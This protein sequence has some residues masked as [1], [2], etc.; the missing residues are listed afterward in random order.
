MSSSLSSSS[1]TLSSFSATPPSQNTTNFQ[2]PVLRMLESCKSTKQLKQIHSIIIKTATN[3]QT[4]HLIYTKILSICS[5]TSDIDPTYINS[6]FT[7]IPNPNTTIYTNA[8]RCFSSCKNPNDISIAFLLY[9]NF[10]SNGFLPNNYTFPFIL[11]SCAKTHRLIEGKQCH[12]HVIKNGFQSD[13]YVVNNLLRMYAVCGEITSVRQLFDESPKR[14]LVSWTT[15]I[16]AYV[17]IG[18]WEEGIHMFFNLCESNLLADEKT[19]VVV[20]SACANIGDL[21]LGRKLHDYIEHHRLTIDIFV[22]NS[23]ID[24]Y[25]K[26]GDSVSAHKVF[27]KMRVRNVVSWNSMILGLSQHGEY[28]QALVVFRKMLNRSFKPD[29]V[30][31]VGVLNCCSNLGMLELGKWVHTYLDKNKIKSDGYI[32][33]A[34]IDMYAKCGNISSSLN[35]FNNMKTKDVYT[36]T[37][38]I[39]GLAMNGQG[40]KALTLF[41]EM[42][43]ELIEPDHVTYVGVL[44]ACSHSGFV[45]LG[46]RYFNEMSNIYNIK[47]RSEHYGCIVDL[48]GRAGLID[49][50]EEFV[51]NMPIEPDGFVLGALLGACRIHNRVQLARVLMEK[52]VEIDHDKDG[53]Y[54]IMSNIY[55]SANK[56]GE[57]GKLRKEMKEKKV[58]KIPGCSCIE[59]DGVVYEFRK[60]DKS[61][62]ENEKIYM[63]LDQL[64]SHLRD[65]NVL[66]I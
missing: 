62:R 4:H 49:E 35:V 25:L 66:L 38:I 61:H 51:R 15:L 14:D 8:I 16:Q 58:K 2:I 1:P 47:P 44:M 27:D 52:I 48:F 26:C 18:N 28:K 19:I 22:E 20:L 65:S 40:K 10:I 30:T 3:L 17:K 37:T 60:G 24:M 29:D 50:A 39:V 33:N 56:W 21:S 5:F 32:G 31:Y 13:L 34:L 55:S 12:V 6:I 63:V 45:N 53:A 41:S 46:Q 54:S 9:R 36:Y 23:L 59:L 64:R 7:Q 43:N 57:V 42:K 11:K